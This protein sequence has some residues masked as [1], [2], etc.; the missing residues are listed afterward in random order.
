MAGMS[1][2]LRRYEEPGI[3][4]E[5]LHGLRI[6]YFDKVHCLCLQ[7]DKLALW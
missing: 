5:Y 2:E 3:G 7:L 6:R 4:L 1:Q